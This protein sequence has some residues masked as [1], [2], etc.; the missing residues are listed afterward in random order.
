MT[1]ENQKHRLTKDGVP[2]DFI[3]SPYVGRTFAKKPRIA[4]IHFTY[5][6]TARSSAEWFRSPQN[7]GS[8]AHVVIE[9]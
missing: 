8:S 5:G 2:V 1:F 6:G 3:A 7:P 9:R 4:V